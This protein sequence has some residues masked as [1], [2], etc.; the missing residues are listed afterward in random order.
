MES[1]WI[2]AWIFQGKTGNQVVSAC[3]CCLTLREQQ[4]N[5]SNT[6]LFARMHAIGR[7]VAY[8]CGFQCQNSFENLSLCEHNFLLT[9]SLW[10]CTAM[11][12]VNKTTQESHDCKQQ[13]HL[14]KWWEWRGERLDCET[15]EQ[16]NQR[17]QLRCEAEHINH[18]QSCWAEE[19]S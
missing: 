14:Q 16:C 1:V 12:E 9:I 10:K 5:N 4:A 11:N 19:T 13:I 15:K 17:L 18:Q 3:A 6:I 2:G 7:D 8:Q